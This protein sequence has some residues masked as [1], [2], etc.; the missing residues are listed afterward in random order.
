[1]TTKRLSEARMKTIK[2]DNATGDEVRALLAE[3]EESRR[4]PPADP[5]RL[6]GTFYE[7]CP[8][9]KRLTNPARVS[10]EAAPDAS[11]L[12]REFIRTMPW[13]I[14]ARGGN[15][16]GHGH[17]IPGVW[18]DDNGALAGKPCAWCALWKRIVAFTAPRPVPS[19]SAAETTCGF[20]MEWVGSCKE[21]RPCPKHATLK[22][23][24]GAPAVRNCGNQI[25]SLMCGEPLCAT[26]GCS[27]SRPSPSADR[28]P[29]PPHILV[30]AQQDSLPLPVGRVV[31]TKPLPA[32]S[33]SAECHAYE[34]EP[35]SHGCK[36]PCGQCFAAS[37]RASRAAKG[38][39]EGGGR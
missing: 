17:Q 13:H 29:L 33:P 34:V 27:H 1:M 26:C 28:A 25:V 39:G 31:A 35:C 8:L 10:G 23:H 5:G 7:R 4:A 20:R 22:C 14:D 32:P 37:V 2:W 3:V 18:D 11:E 30:S 36:G 19:H 38:D 15:G 12:L 9:C 24:C 16:P 6:D 21:P